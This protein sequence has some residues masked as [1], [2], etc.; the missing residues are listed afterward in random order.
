MVKVEGINIGR[1]CHIGVGCIIQSYGLI[2]FED[3]VGVG[4]NST[5]FAGTDDYHGSGFQGLGVFGDKYRNITKAPVTLK[6]HVHVGIGS[7]I[8]PG[9]TIGEG[10]SVGAGS[11][12]TR[13]LPE[14]TICIGS[15]CKPVKEKTREKQLAMEKEFLKEYYG[16]L[17]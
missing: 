8:L 3:F 12:V 13:D 4:A 16:Q 14:C 5:I 7:I 2:T 15:P 1:F 10:C 17:G 9:V 11:I 6:R